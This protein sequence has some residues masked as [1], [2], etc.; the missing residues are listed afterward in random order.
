[1]HLHWVVAASGCEN[2]GCNFAVATGWAIDW[3]TPDVDGVAVIVVL[4]VDALYVGVFCMFV[5]CW[6][7][8]VVLVVFGCVSCDFVVIVVG[9]GVVIGLTGVCKKVCNGC[10]LRRL[11]NT[12][13]W[14]N[15]TI[16]SHE[17]QSK[18][19]ATTTTINNTQINTK[20][21]DR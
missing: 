1:M 20:N 18:M 7:V 5:G 21:S 8:C 15:Q 6:I 10:R 13:Q 19:K 11:Y 17:N 4:L 2:A 9:I 16:N 3:G 12:K 14:K